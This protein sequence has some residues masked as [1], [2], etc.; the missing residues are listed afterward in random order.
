[1]AKYDP[2]KKYGWEEDTVF[3]LSGNEFGYILNTMRTVLATPEAQRILMLNE[4][5]NTVE[6]ILKRNVE[7]GNVKPVDLQSPPDLHKVVEEAE[8]KS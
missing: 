3:E 2:N 7:T 6:D 8:D 5:N 4:A 1:M